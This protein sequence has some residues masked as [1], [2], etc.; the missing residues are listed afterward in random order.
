MAGGF[1]GHRSTIAS[2]SR[3]G[4]QRRRGAATLYFDAESGLLV[5]QVRYADSPVGR[6]PT[7]IDYADYR[8]VAGVKMPFTGSLTWLDGQEPSS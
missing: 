8:D 6:I 7:L 3:A 1:P 4:D 5:R 2:R